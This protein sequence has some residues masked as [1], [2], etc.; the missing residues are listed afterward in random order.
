MRDNDFGRYVRA[1]REQRGLTMKDFADLSGWP[2]TTVSGIE[3]G[4]LDPPDDEYFPIYTRLLGVPPAEL[5]RLA[6]NHRRPKMSN[7]QPQPGGLTPEQMMQQMMQMMQM[8]QAAQQPGT[9]YPPAG[10]LAY[11]GMM[12]PMMPPPATT[13][14]TLL[15]VPMKYRLYDGSTCRYYRQME[16]PAGVPLEQ[17]IDS[18]IRQGYPIDTWAPKQQYGGGRGN[19]GGG[20]YR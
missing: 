19:Y 12:P 15:M 14:P 6:D 20:G 13:G 7:D 1:A 10:M 9:G 2:V 18:L 16:C 11:P 5:Q 3:R 17:F 4:T 8:Q